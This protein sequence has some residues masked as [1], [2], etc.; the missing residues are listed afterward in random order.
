LVN[1]FVHRDYTDFSGGL[2]VFIYPK[3]LEIWNSG[4]L[5]EGITVKGL[6]TGHISV[7]R[8]PDIAHVLYLR[9]M[10]EKLGRGSVLIQKACVDRGLPK[11]EW[12]SDRGVTLTFFAPEI[13]PEDGTKQ[14]PSRDQ[15]GTKQGPSNDQIKLLIFFKTERTIK[16]MMNLAKR[17]N[18]TKF[19]NSV[20]KQLLDSG[21]LEMT[22]PDNP[23]NPHQKYRVTE[24]GVAAMGVQGL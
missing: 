11:P 9:G 21:W 4:E 7:L 2:S 3:R 17:S 12:K 14:G 20:V 23:T 6:N 1:A 24:K 5:P 8:N 16:E 22:D 15:V 18:R 13:S 10:M 19:R